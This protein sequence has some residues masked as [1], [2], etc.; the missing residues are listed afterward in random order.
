MMFVCTNGINDA[1][2]EQLETLPWNELVANIQK[3]FPILTE[4]GNILK[5]KGCAWLK[6]R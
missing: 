3:L 5:L 6:V 1:E 4:D 2:Q